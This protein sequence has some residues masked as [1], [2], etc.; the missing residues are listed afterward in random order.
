MA[1]GQNLGLQ[2][3]AGELRA[4]QGGKQYP[5]DNQHGMGQPTDSDR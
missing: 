5:E 3:G 2:G 4:S 1:Q